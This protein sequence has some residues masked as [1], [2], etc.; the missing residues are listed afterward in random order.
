MTDLTPLFNQALAKRH[1]PAVA[2]CP[3]STEHL[4]EFLKEAYRIVCCHL[5]RTVQSISLTVI[6]LSYSL[7]KC[8]P[9]LNTA[10]LPIHCTTTPPRPP[11]PHPL[12]AP[13]P[14]LNRPTTRRNRCRDQ[15]ASTRAQ[16]LNPFTS[17]CRSLATEHRNISPAEAISHTAR[18]SRLM[19]SRR[20][21]R[22]KKLRTRRRRK[23]PKSARRA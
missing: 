22:R 18:R 4:D 14:I 13:N 7:F 20:F 10:I 5:Y 11:L 6:E 3:L 16:C 15:A 21:S 19:G 12:T 2:N 17:R 1:A 9:A 23:P 8:L